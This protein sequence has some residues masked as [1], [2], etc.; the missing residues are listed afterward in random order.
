MRRSPRLF[1]QVANILLKL[2]TSPSVVG[3]WFEECLAESTEE[4]L[5][6]IGDDCAKDE[7]VEEEA[8]SLTTLSHPDS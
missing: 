3:G 1:H 7:E 6:Q 2:V 4:Q 8:Q 5:K